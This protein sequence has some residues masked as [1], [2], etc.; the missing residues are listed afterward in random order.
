MKSAKLING[1]VQII[2]ISKPILNSPGA[3]IRVLG[4]GLCGSDIVKI[5]HATPET[6]DKIVLGHE[7][8]GVIEEINACV[9]TV[10]NYAVLKVNLAEAAER[11]YRRTGLKHK[12]VCVLD[13]KGCLT[14][15]RYNEAGVVAADAV[16]V[17]AVEVYLRICITI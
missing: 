10:K 9:S 12:Q 15:A 4:C 6:E 14:A 2:D 7:V 8:V 5:K 16:V 1:K 3:I 11:V 13:I 17:T